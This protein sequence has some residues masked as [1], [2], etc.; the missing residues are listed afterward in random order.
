VVLKDNLPKQPNVP[1]CF[2]HIERDGLPLLS[3]PCEFED[4]DL[5]KFQVVTEGDKPCPYNKT[6]KCPPVPIQN[7]D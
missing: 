2:M 7:D 4:I 1:I 5:D 3:V 6:M